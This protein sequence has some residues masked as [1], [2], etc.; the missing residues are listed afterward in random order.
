MWRLLVGLGLGCAGGSRTTEGE[1]PP[2]NSETPTCAEVLFYADADADGY[3]DHN[4]A[5]WACEAPTGWVENLADCDDTR[6]DAHPDAAEVCNREDDDCDGEID[7]HA[8]DA[9]RWFAD[10]DA[11]GFGD[12]SAATLACDGAAST[13]TDDSDCDDDEPTVYP[14]AA[15]LCDELDN[16]CDGVVDE[17]FDKDEDGYLDAEFCGDDCDDN[18]DAVHPEAEEICSNGIDDD[19][20]D[21]ALCGFHG[22]TA[23]V[24]Q[25]SLVFEGV[26]VGA[27]MGPFL[28]EDLDGDGTAEFI[29]AAPRTDVVTT[30]AGRVHLFSGVSSGSYT[31][32]DADAVWSNDGKGEVAGRALAVGDFDGDGGGEL[33]ISSPFDQAVYLLSDPMT[34]GDLTDGLAITGSSD[35]FGSHLSAPD[36]DGDGVSELAIGAYYEEGLVAAGGAFFLLEDPRAS[37]EGWRIDGTREGGLLGGEAL[38][39]DLDATGAMDLVLS[40]Y[41]AEFNTGAVF[42]FYDPSGN[43]LVDNDADIELAGE[44]P[45]DFFGTALAAGDVDGDGKTDLAIGARYAGVPDVAMLSGSDGA[46]YLYSGEDLEPTADVLF[47]GSVASLGASVA[48]G[49]LDGDGLDDLVAGA[50]GGTASV[51]TFYGPLEGS[52][53]ASDA[54]GTVTGGGGNLGHRVALADM[55]GD[56]WQDLLTTD[57]GEEVFSAYIGSLYIIPGGT[58]L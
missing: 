34:G 36:V 45:G 11:D 44:T 13:V 16:D 27:G 2:A 25:A 31:L 35:W 12:S 8:A 55:D 32:D 23:T 42:A 14:D 1:S 15:E 30:D 22:G 40:A 47:D 26:E 54:D 4:T 56:G 29:I 51:L 21:T 49:D 58:G 52:F 24:D 33:V 46:V 19:C 17:G 50:P 48:L 3:G 41:A 9:A 57:P 43:D 6:P 20:D 28:L 18:R 39:V 38:W 5:Q 37:D 10:T 7:E 53:L